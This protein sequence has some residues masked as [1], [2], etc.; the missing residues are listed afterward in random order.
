MFNFFSSSFA[1]VAESALK[2][3][4][5]LN[6]NRSVRSAPS[7]EYQRLTINPGKPK[8]PISDSHTKRVHGS[9]RVKVLK[10]HRVK[11]GSR[12]GITVKPVLVVKTSRKEEGNLKSKKHK[13]LPSSNFFI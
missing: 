7:R 2:K 9:P 10:T 3:A 4:R 1:I 5:D 11:E 8:K 12:R 6:R 13:V